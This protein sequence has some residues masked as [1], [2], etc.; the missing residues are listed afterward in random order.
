MRVAPTLWKI[1]IN[2]GHRSISPSSTRWNSMQDSEMATTHGVPFY[3]SHSAT[4][5]QSTQRERNKNKPVCFS[6]KKKNDFSR[7]FRVDRNC[8]RAHHS[9]RQRQFF[10]IYYL[11][12]CKIIAWK[13]TTTTMTTTTKSYFYMLD[14]SISVRWRSH[15]FFLLLL[16]PFTWTTQAQI[17]AVVL[18]V[19]KTK[20][21]GK[22][23]WLRMNSV[24]NRNYFIEIF[25]SIGRFEANA[26]NVTSNFFVFTEC[27]LYRWCRNFI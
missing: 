16:F 25:H 20:K 1:N 8:T 12:S 26:S 24:H 5:N 11:R 18:F 17:C 2:N 21:L 14:C 19:K 3:S 4:Q 22:P 7:C 13:W 23:Q 6:K 9:E 15:V 10:F 27:A